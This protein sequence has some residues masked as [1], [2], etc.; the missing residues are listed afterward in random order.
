MFDPVTDSEILGVKLNPFFYQHAV[1][2]VG[3]MT[4]SEYDVISFYV[5]L[6][7]NNTRRPVSF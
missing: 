1:S 6:I 5:A 3:R 4:R 2:V 7:S